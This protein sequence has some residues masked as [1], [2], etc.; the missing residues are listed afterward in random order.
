MTEETREE[1]KRVVIELTND[2]YEFI[3]MV[4]SFVGLEWR[5]MLIKGVL[6]IIDDFGGEEKFV[7]ALKTALEATKRIV[8]K[9]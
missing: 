5:E 9:E 6:A 8:S 7:E 1:I 2:D 4:K 3:R